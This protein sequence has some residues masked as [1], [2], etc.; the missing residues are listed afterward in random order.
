MMRIVHVITIQF[1]GPLRRPSAYSDIR[2]TPE[3]VAPCDKRGILRRIKKGVQD[4]DFS[5]ETLI[6]ASSA[7]ISSHYENRLAQ[8]CGTAS[9]CAPVRLNGVWRG[10]K[11]RI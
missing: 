5:S 7:S 10:R 4:S 2:T 8:N 11:Q 9:R 3:P 6:M 1:R